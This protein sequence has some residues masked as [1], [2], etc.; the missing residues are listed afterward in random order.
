MGLSAP[1]ARAE[2]REEA[3]TKDVTEVEEK[4]ELSS[5]LSS[6]QKTLETTSVEHVEARLSNGLRVIA[7][8]DPTPGLVA[9][10]TW[11]SVGSGDEITPGSTG[12]W[13]R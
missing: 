1:S 11:I 5:P 6:P 13:D 8:K 12:C 3:G 2:G 7:I 10:Q 9:V 4:V